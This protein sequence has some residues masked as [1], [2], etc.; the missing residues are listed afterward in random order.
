MLSQMTTVERMFIFQFRIAFFRVT[1][2]VHMLHIQINI[3]PETRGVVSDIDHATAN[4]W[5]ASYKT[6]LRH[7]PWISTSMN[8]NGARR[9]QIKLWNKIGHDSGI[10]MLQFK[11]NIVACWTFFWNCLCVALI[12]SHRNYVIYAYKISSCYVMI[13]QKCPSTFFLDRNIAQKKRNVHIK[14]LMII[15]M[16]KSLAQP[17]FLNCS[18]VQVAMIRK[19]P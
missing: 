9:I 5:Y 2:M 13:K 12:I 3:Y 16:S 1:C 11:A 7:L 18:A 14:P 4:Q 10:D 17:H 8:A 6:L 19:V 15:E